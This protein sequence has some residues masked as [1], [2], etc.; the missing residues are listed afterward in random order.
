MQLMQRFIFY[1]VTFPWKFDKKIPLAFI[2]NFNQWLEN[3]DV[4]FFNF[5][6]TVLV[7]MSTLEK[8]LCLNTHMFNVL[9]FKW[10]N[11][12][13][14]RVRNK[15]HRTDWTVFVSICLN[16]DI[17]GIISMC[18]ACQHVKNVKITECTFSRHA[19]Y[20]SSCPRDQRR[21]CSNYQLFHESVS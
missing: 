14:S 11:S 19:Q 1:R 4:F 5:T 15:P 12:C 17:L 9:N 6:I 3:K 13:G 21:I 16:R 20:R 2:I 18:L 10:H 7:S 8:Y